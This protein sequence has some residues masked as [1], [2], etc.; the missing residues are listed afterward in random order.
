MINLLVHDPQTRS[1]VPVSYK[2]M[3][4]ELLKWLTP[5]DTM[6]APG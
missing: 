4:I 1:T 6:P 3:Q 2:R 5:A